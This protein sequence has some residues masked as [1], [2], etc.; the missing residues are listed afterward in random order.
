MKFTRKNYKPNDKKYK[1]YNSDLCNDEMS[2]ND[3]ELA[4]LRS[5]VD[6]SEKEVKKGLVNGPEIIKIID[7][8]EK[9]LIDKKLICYGGTAINN[10]LPKH[11][12]FYDRSSEIPDY[13]FYSP[14]ALNDALEL[15]DIY[16][17]AGYNEVEAKAGVHYGT[18]KVFVNFIPI[19]DITFLENSLFDAIYDEAIKVNKILYAPPNFLRMNMYLELSRPQGDVSR[20]EKVLK[21]LNL[22]NEFY[23]L[24]DIDGCSKVE[25]LRGMEQDT[26]SER[27]HIAVRDSFIS[28]GAVFFGGYGTSLYTKYMPDKQRKLISKIPDFDVLYEKPEKLAELTVDKLKKIGIKHISIV[29][30][31]EIGEILPLHYE[32]RI[33]KETIAFIY[34]PV[35]C[36][37]YNTI[38]LKDKKINV[39]TID[40]ILV[41]Y[42]A[43]WYVEKPYYYRERLMCM[44][45]FLFALEDDNRLSQKGLLKRFS[46]SCYGKQ[47]T[48]TDIRQLKTLKF[49]ELRNK[50]GTQEYDMWFLKYNPN[51]KKH[52]ESKEK[53]KLVK[54]KKS[55]TDYKKKYKSKSILSEIFNNI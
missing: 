28:E 49:K 33:G 5:A 17:D 14:N 51:E 54:T 43:F 42:L 40:T 21:R 50:K 8:L 15:A 44:I 20:W 31:D 1:M 12:Q 24:N 7:I 16:H 29:K 53:S 48:L 23:P 30:H 27:I 6:E 9:F 46:I 4:I 47:N 13:D 10:I 22:L 41:F 38:I 52:Y 25:F 55:K 26:D 39:A 19:A 32:I 45:K 3:C 11:V 36:H 37:S 18:F 34:A 2:F 35:A